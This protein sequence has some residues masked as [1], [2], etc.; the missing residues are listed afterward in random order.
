MRGRQ[1]FGII[2]P[3]L[4]FSTFL[5]S[6][7]LGVF[8]NQPWSE[9]DQCCPII[10][11]GRCRGWKSHL[12]LLRDCS[13]TRAWQHLSL[14]SGF[15]SRLPE[16]AA[17]VGSLVGDGGGAGAASSDWAAKPKSFKVGPT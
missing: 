7:E 2:K 3:F 15:L 13:Q 4:S 14:S 9:G 1:P 16:Q 11:S 10:Y 6:Q 12:R 17:P 5:E 8:G